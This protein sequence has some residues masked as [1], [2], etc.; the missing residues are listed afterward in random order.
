MGLLFRVVDLDSSEDLVLLI[1]FIIEVNLLLGSNV[2][3]IGR[4]VRC[5]YLSWDNNCDTWGM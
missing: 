4:G 3:T 5:H 1:S 2:G